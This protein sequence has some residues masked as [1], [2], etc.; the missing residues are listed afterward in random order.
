M[1]HTVGFAFYHH[2]LSPPRESVF[3]SFRNFT[4][5]SRSFRFGAN[6]L[7]ENLAECLLEVK[8]EFIDGRRV[9]V[10]EDRKLY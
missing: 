9:I 8:V 1:G 5:D 3:Y 10:D 2:P 7:P 6:P 4:H